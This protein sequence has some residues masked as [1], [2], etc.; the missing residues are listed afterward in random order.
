MS[1][2][3]DRVIVSGLLFGLFLNAAWAGFLVYGAFKLA[4]LVF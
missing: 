3:S 4:E 2:L 1:G